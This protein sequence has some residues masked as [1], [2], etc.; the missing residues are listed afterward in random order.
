MK[1][2]NDKTLTKTAIPVQVE[3]LKKV[4]NEDLDKIFLVGGCVRDI[5]SGTVPEDVDLLA[6]LPPQKL[7]DMGFIYVDPKTALPLF[8][9]HHRE[10]GKI[11][12]ALPR[13]KAGDKPTGGYSGIIENDV[14]EDLRRRDFTINAMA[15][16][17]S[18][19]E[20]IDP[21]NGQKDLS[22]RIVRHVS[23]A[24]TEDPLRVFRA[25]RFACKGF[26]IAPE[27][28]DLIRTMNT[29]LNHLPPERIYNEMMKAMTEEYPERFFLY[30]IRSGVSREL[31]NE[32]YQMADVIAGPPQYHPEG[33]TFNHAVNVLRFVAGRTRCKYTRLAAFLH[34]IGKIETPKEELPRHIDHEN[35]GIAVVRRFL[36]RLRGD[37]RCKKICAEITKHHMKAEQFRHMRRG[38]QMRFVNML[39]KADLIDPLLHVVEAD[40]GKDISPAVAPFREV[41]GYN[42]AELGLTAKD[43]ENRSPEQIQDLILQRQL[44]RLRK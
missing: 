16:N 2:C 23:E 32:V 41:A 6:V 39:H 22:D 33:T 42:T 17:L 12:I 34:D 30:L 9:M 7:L 24:F 19:W 8:T 4:L 40:Y 15:Y 13:K 35:R 5:L 1:R 27:T 36:N 14:R 29:G 3:E 38:K 31:F 20:L 26:T 10:L 28:M 43:F 18:T 37:N 21:F 44:E 11:E 25:F